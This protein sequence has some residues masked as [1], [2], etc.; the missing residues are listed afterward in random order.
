MVNIVFECHN[1]KVSQK[2]K[3]INVKSEKVVFNGQPI[4]LKYYDCPVCR[5]RNFVQAD[6]KISSKLLSDCAKQIRI[7]ML[8]NAKGKAGKQSG[9]AKKSQSHLRKIRNA[10]QSML[11]GKQ[12]NT[13][14][15]LHFVPYRIVGEENDKQANEM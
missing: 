6:N 7:Q 13:G 2:E 15:I 12:V 1:C 3:P 9:K 10:L 5:A 11:D 8:L 4:D 14:E